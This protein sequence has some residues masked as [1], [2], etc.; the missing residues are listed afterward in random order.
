MTEKERSLGNRWFEEV[1]NKHRRDAIGE[2]LAPDGVIHDGSTD[3]IGPDGFYPFFE[4]L[5][6]AFPDMRVAIHD[7]IAE[8]DRIC[9]HWSATARH[10]GDGLGFPPTGKSLAV[11]GISILRVAGGKVVEAWQNWDMLGLLEQIQGQG[12]SATYIGS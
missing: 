6:G 5:H 12:K 7:T 1:W 11:T 10:T 3:S 2:I 4:R 9:V 8:H